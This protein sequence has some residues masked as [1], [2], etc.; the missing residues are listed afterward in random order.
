MPELFITGGITS[1]VTYLGIVV[2]SSVP[3]ATGDPSAAAE[4]NAVAPTSTAP[5]AAPSVFDFM[6]IPP[7]DGLF[8]MPIEWQIPALLFL[9]AVTNFTDFNQYP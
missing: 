6:S 3:P 7:V 2:G 5:K 1:G 8:L 4:C 9:I